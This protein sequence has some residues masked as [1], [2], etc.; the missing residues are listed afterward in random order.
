MRAQGLALDARLGLPARTAVAVGAPAAA[1]NLNSAASSRA[2]PSRL[3]PLLQPSESA[4]TQVLHVNAAPLLP[5]ALPT[6]TSAPSQ[7]IYPE[8]PPAF[9]ASAAPAAI[10]APAVS[11]ID[12]DRE[13][14]GG[15]LAHDER[16]RRLAARFASALADVEP[17][18]RALRGPAAPKLQRARRLWPESV[19]VVLGSQK[20]PWTLSAAL[21]LVRELPEDVLGAGAA[22]AAGHESLQA[23]WFC[24]SAS[25]SS[26][27]GETRMASVV[28]TAAPSTPASSAATTYACFLCFQALEEPAAAEAED[29]GRGGAGAGLVGEATM[30]EIQRQIA[31]L[32]LFGMPNDFDPAPPASIAGSS[33]CGRDR[34][35]EEEEERDGRWWGARLWIVRGAACL[36][37][38]QLLSEF[39]R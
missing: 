32:Y 10:S 15:R 12:I 26:P 11:V 39:T 6:C 24:A 31:A 25:T 33:G 22:P 27:A 29:G 30:R 23:A 38:Q 18:R 13:T 37:A 2:Q 14:D 1:S 28:V 7:N 36:G 5:G 4:G 9:S 19:T 16:A 35:A 20:G 3:P 8:L 34:G 17:L 21:E